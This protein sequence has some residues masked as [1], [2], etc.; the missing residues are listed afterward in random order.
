M[1]CSKIYDKILKIHYVFPSAYVLHGREDQNK[2]LSF[3]SAQKG[4]TDT[5]KHVLIGYH[6]EP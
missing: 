6:E 3:S 5:R 1:Q 2:G 4:E